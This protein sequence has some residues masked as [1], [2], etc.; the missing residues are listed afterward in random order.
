MWVDSECAC[1]VT[2]HPSLAGLMLRVCEASRAALKLRGA[3]LPAALRGPLAAHLARACREMHALR[4]GLASPPRLSVD[5]S[6]RDV[7]RGDI[8]SQPRRAGRAA[9]PPLSA[10]TVEITKTAVLADLARAAACELR[11]AGVTITLDDFGTGYSSLTHRRELPIDRVKIDRSFVADCPVSRSATAILLAITRLAHDLGET[12][13]A[14]GVESAA[15]V[16][17]V[18][19]LGCDLAQ[20]YL[21]SP[22]M[23]PEECRA[24]LER[25]EKELL[26]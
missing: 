18:R 11:I 14:E 21:L 23:P 1:T 12:V 5:L 9:D 26:P 25:A 10:P 4:E 6:A 7:Q 20:G 2:R 16:Q 24:F 13:V 8:C 17:L 22:P 19:A 15:Q 3:I